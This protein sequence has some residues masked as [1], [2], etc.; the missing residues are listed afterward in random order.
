MN[1]SM[2][3]RAERQKL[4]NELQAMSGGAQPQQ[5]MGPMAQKAKIEREAEQASLSVGGLI[6]APMAAS[7][8]MSS[9]EGEGLPGGEL[10]FAARIARDAAKIYLA[11][12]GMEVPGLEIVQT[13]EDGG[14]DHPEDNPT[15]VDAALAEEKE[16]SE[17]PIILG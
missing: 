11:A 10:V 1:R 15:G 17:S 12:N 4:M 8:I 2:N 13:G 9:P 14:V 3:K 5:V 7:I 16:K 6:Y